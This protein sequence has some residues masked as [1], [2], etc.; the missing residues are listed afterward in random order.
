MAKLASIATGNF[1][2]AGTW[3]VIDPTLYANSETSTVTCPTAYSNVARSAQQTPGAITVS[4]IGVKLSVRTGTTGTM[5]VHIAN[6]AHTEVAGTAVTINTAD[7]PVAASADLNGGWHFFKLATPVALA[8]ATLYEVEAK[9]SSASQI[10]L[11][12]SAATNGLSCAL[13]TTTTAAPAA[14]DDLFV[15]GEYTGTGTSNSFVVTNDNTATTDFGAASTS[16]VTPAVAI[17]NKGALKYGTSAATAYY[18]KVSGNFIVYSGG[19]FNMGAPTTEIPRDSTA[20]L[21]FDCGANVDFGLTVRNLGTI[22]TAGLSRTS[23]KD[24]FYC[25]LNTNEAANSTSLGVDTDTG[26]LDND[27]I[28]LGTTSRTYTECETGTLNG[29]A[30]AS[31]LTVDGFAGSGGGI[32]YAHSGTSPAQ[33]EVLLLTRNVIIQG[34]TALLAAFVDLKATCTSTFS[35]TAF[36][37][38][39]SSTA[40]KRGVDI[41]NTT[42]TATFDYC[43]IRNFE[44][45]F[46]RGY[47]LTSGSGT[48]VALTNCATYFTGSDM[49]INVSTTGTWSITNC[50]FMRGGTNATGVSLADVGGTI[51][52][53]RIIGHGN[54]STGGLGVTQVAELGSW[55]DIN[56]HGCQGVGVNMTTFYIGTITNLTIWRN[57]ALGLSVASGDFTIDNLV[58]FG[59]GLANIRG[60]TSGVLRL[61]NPTLNGDTTFS[62][63][64]GISLAN[65]TTGFSAIINGGSFGVASGIL[66]THSTADINAGAQTY[67]LYQIRMYGT[68]LASATE[69]GTQANLSPSA[70]IGAEKLDNTAGNHKTWKRYGTIAIETTTTHTGGFS[71]KMTPNDASFKLES[72]GAFGGFKVAVANGATVTPTV[73]VYEDGSYNGARA[74]LI[75]K[76]NDAMGITAD[77]VLDTATAASDLAWEALSGTTA[78]VTD[79]G[80]LEFVVD[81]N[82]TAG[83]LYVDSFSVT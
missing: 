62:T 11:F 77:T 28:A 53:L 37:W 4:H 18:L 56:I 43:I 68:T 65:S 10:G 31:T 1:T 3:G 70:Y 20:T 32:L 67:S 45:G 16:L 81:C 47:N 7:L 51:S 57:A 82:G 71:V 26:W 8:A 55:S 13:I 74:R 52:G 60:T 27:E 34:A 59:N 30:G 14:G 54:S 79:D 6:S 44:N 12:A 80:T 42:N 22:K 5:T 63:P 73:Y 25:L 76:R 2:T 72:S 29:N 40:N 64:S 46:A 36:K 39:G 41:A 21:L 23:G 48:S 35:W 50:V 69:I 24:V 58:A 19:E 83:N 38:M 61:N 66:T 15:N 49:F 33:G 9:T 78:A 17:S 75:V